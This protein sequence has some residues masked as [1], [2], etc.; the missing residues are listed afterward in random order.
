[1][2]RSSP[3]H[4][5]QH[6]TTDD[7]PVHCW[8]ISLLSLLTQNSRLKLCSSQLSVISESRSSPES[9]MRPASSRAFRILVLTTSRPFS[10]DQTSKSVYSFVTFLLL[11]KEAWFVLPQPPLRTLSF[12]LSMNMKWHSCGA[13]RPKKVWDLALY[14]SACLV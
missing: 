8:F 12:M 14:L 13:D 4:L 10:S 2:L 11:S 5:P 9:Q 6:A 1:M 3:Q 7:S